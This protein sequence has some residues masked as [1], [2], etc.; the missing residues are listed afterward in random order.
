KGDRVLREIRCVEGERVAPIEAA[1]GESARA[2]RN[3]DPKL[4]VGQEASARRVNERGLVP[5]LARPLENERAQ[6]DPR[7]LDCAVR[8]PYDAR[9][10]DSVSGSPSRDSVSARSARRAITRRYPDPV[11]F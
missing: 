10:I 6:R 7:Y 5:E 4:C 3:L 9:T 11:L 2:R 8:T 1:A